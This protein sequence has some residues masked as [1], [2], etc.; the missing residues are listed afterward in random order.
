[1][2]GGMLRGLEEMSM[3]GD[4]GPAQSNSFIVQQ[5]PEMRERIMKGRD[6]KA[7]AKYQMDHFFNADANDPKEDM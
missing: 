4:G 7:I 3:M 2:L 5:L 6:Y 1:M